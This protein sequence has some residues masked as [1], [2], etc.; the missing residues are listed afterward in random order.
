MTSGDSATSSAESLANAVATCRPANVDLHVATVDPAQF[1]Q[2]LH[3]RVDSCLSILDICR[4][5]HQHADTPRSLRLLRA[6][7][8]RPR[9]HAAEQCDEL[10]P[11]HK[12]P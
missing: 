2:T 4:Q 12:T 1:S 11:S 9:R 5:A 8:K 10:A 7:R 6:R 3:E